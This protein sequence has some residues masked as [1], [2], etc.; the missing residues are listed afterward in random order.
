MGLSVVTT[1]EIKAASYDLT[2]LATAK[3]ELSIPTSDTSKDNFLKRGITQVSQAMANNTNRVF[4]VEQIKDELYLD[5]DPYPYQ[6][7]GTIE[8][9]QLSRFPVVDLLE[10]FQ[11]TSVGVTVTL[12]E[13]TD[14]RL[15]AA[16]GALLRLNAFTGVQVSWEPLPV[17]VRYSA[18]YGDLI[19]GEAQTIPVPAGPYVVNVTQKTDFALDR[20]VTYAIGGAELVAVNG[21]PNAGE[22]SVA[23]GAYTF[24]VAD[25]GKGVLIDYIVNDTPADLEYAVL[26][27]VTQRNAQRGRDPMLMSISQPNLGDKRWWVGTANG[28]AGAFPPEIQGLLDTYKVPVIA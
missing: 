14:F 18:G 11:T 21:L 8:P 26:T 4:V 20:G 12:V 2:D 10:V 23:A 7:P 5:Q 25:A 22:Y 9:L 15:D 16:N 19:E 1:I 13:G 6:V 3:D 27:L 24:N 17:T 28:Q